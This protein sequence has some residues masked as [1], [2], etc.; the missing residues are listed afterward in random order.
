MIVAPPLRL[1]IVAHFKR[2][3]KWFS[4]LSTNCPKVCKT[5]QNTKK[6]HMLKQKHFLKKGIFMN[7]LRRTKFFAS[8]YPVDIVLML[9]LLMLLIH[10]GVSLFSEQ[11]VSQERTTIDIIARTSAAAIFGYFLSAPAASTSSGTTAIGGKAVTLVSSEK[12]ADTPQNAIGFQTG[13]AGETLTPGSVQTTSGE[14]NYR[15]SRILFLSAVGGVCLIFLLIL[16]NCDTVPESA[17][18][19]ISQFRDFIAASIGFLISCGKS[20]GG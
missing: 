11:G 13:D 10:A 3:E 17:A 20:R 16:R 4:R 6:M 18:A 7:K 8:V 2:P 9:F 14:P 15:I 1:A 19:T 12:T 5:A